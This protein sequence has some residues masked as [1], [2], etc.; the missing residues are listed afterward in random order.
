MAVAD[1]VEDLVHDHADLNRRV[2]ALGAAV[3]QL[4]RAALAG[5]AAQLEALRELLFLH[6]AREE[7]GLF[8]F[9]SD[10]EADLADQV[11]AM[12][13]AHDTICGALA[14]MCH[15]A[16]SGAEPG[17]LAL[18]FQ[19]FESAYA[20]HARTEADLL[21]E[22]GRRLSPEQREQLAAIVDGL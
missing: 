18:V 16:S 12:A 6:F 21:D 19:R 8:P 15:L 7:E 1:A 5:F 9:V 17:T 22:L 3:P 20:A 4:D 11:N 10:C 14:R 2:L 13:S